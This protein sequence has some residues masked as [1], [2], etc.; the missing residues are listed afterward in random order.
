MRRLIAHLRS[1]RL[2][3]VLL[4]YIVGYAALTT[5]IPQ[6]GVAT[7]IEIA[8]WRA[9]YPLW[10]GVAAG[11]GL[12]RAY[13]SPLFVLPATLLIASTAA[14]SWRRGS[15]ARLLWA[16]RRGT[17][18]ALA[19]C[20]VESP[21][22]I[23]GTAGEKASE[24]RLVDALRSL[25]LTAAS[26][27]AGIRATSRLW[28]AWGSAAFHWSLVALFGVALVGQ[29]VKWEGVIGVPVGH[30]VTDVARDYGFL[31]RGPLAAAEPSSGYT[32]AV[33]EMDLGHVEDGIDRGH[34]PLVRLMEGD[35]VLAE[36]RVFPNS[37]LSHGTTFVHRGEQWGLAVVA[38]LETTA[39]AEIGRRN[40]LFDFV[41]TGGTGRLFIEDV[42]PPETGIE[43]LQYAVVLDPSGDEFV[44]DLATD[45]RVEVTP[46]DSADASTTV[47]RPGD[48]VTF[49]G[50]QVSLRIVDVTRYV[51]LFV[52][53]DP[54]IWAV[55]ALFA[56]AMVTGS[57]ALLVHP[58]AVVAVPAQAAGG[59]DVLNVIVLSRK[60]DPLFRHRVDEALA[61]L[62][63]DEEESG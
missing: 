61:R 10:A 49:P 27:G 48:V 1:P 52:V 44:A 16:L 53:H 13:W 28:A 62:A 29:A 23:V 18:E 36:R 19:A 30:S 54:T 46:L 20:A 9:A 6:A 35:R 41:P 39:S 11:L 45:P 42:M 2:A 21:H 38:A 34:A 56:V 33:P 26:D 7:D 4:V 14:C 47:M 8:Q 58:R 60:M 63:A 25:G 31:A 43:R 24:E 15:H 22:A 51:R 3:V 57:F 32:I 37:P 59:S 50:G 17:S 55:Y 5:I 12:E 40:Y